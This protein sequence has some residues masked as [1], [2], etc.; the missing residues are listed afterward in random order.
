MY[1]RIK[2]NK[3]SLTKFLENFFK[4]N[5]YLIVFLIKK[6]NLKKILN[7]LYDCIHV[8]IHITLEYV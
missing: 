8:E 6:T 1:L 3:D 2:C 7:I 4:K 5:L